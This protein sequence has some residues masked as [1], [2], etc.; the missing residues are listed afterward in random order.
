MIW[1]VENRGRSFRWTGPLYAFN[2]LMKFFLAIAILAALAFF[3]LKHGSIN[4]DSKAST[5]IQAEATPGGSNYFKRPLD[6]THE[7]ID[8]VK[9]QR[10]EDNY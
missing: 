7:V 3:F 6:R 9:K 10:R 1:E 2:K 5:T 4:K 8:Q